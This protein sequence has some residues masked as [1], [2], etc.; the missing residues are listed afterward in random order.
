M[1]GENG[2]RRL[3]QQASNEA[4]TPGARGQKTLQRRA[5]PSDD[6]HGVQHMYLAASLWYEVIGL[7]RDPCE[8]RQRIE[9]SQ[10]VH[11]AH[12]SHAIRHERRGFLLAPLPL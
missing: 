10:P 5:S 9:N 2:F 1:F 6:R 4:I 11:S 7:H 12:V 8:K 3:P